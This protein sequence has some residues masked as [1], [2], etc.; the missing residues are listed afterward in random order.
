MI[1]NGISYNHKNWF[2]IVRD[3]I[4]CLAT[5]AGGDIL[6]MQREEIIDEEM[7]V[8][9]VLLMFFKSENSFSNRTR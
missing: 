6:W 4:V 5:F 3:S 9:E 7:R 1:R 2:S 8:V